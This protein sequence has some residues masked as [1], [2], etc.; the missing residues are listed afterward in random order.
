[1][2]ELSFYFLSHINDD[3]PT[4]MVPTE[5]THIAGFTMMRLGHSWHTTLFTALKQPLYANYTSC[6]SMSRNVLCFNIV[7][8]KK[9]AL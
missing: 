6:T 2:N 1:V 7:I 9:N 8:T 4:M 3:L 5:Y